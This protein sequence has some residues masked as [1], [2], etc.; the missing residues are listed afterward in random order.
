MPVGSAALRVELPALGA[1]VGIQCEDFAVGGAGV[2]GVTDLQW[3]VLVFR[4]C[5]GALRDVAGVE[6]PGNLQRVDVTLVD[7]I[8]RRKPI[9]CRGVAPV[10]PVLLLGAWRHRDDSRHA[11]GADHV[12]GDEHVTHGRDNTDGQYAGQAISATTCLRTRSANQRRVNQRN[13]QADHGK[14]QYA[15]HQRPVVQACIPDRPERSQY[16]G[17]AIQHCALEF[18][19]CDQRTTDQHRQPHQQ[20]EPAPAQC[21]QVAAATCQTEPDQSDQHAQPEQ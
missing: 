10:C 3:R 14:G 1:G 2:N 9:A 6:G 4:T 15:G 13:H 7:L 17:D 21:H 11:A 5:A 19:G 18:P 16:Q 8:Q 12:A 20:E